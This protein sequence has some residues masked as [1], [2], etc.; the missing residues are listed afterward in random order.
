MALCS[1][2]WAPAVVTVYLTPSH[3]HSPLA[4]PTC[5]V[6]SSLSPSLSLPASHSR[7]APSGATTELAWTGRCTASAL[8]GTE[9]GK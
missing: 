8:S 3:S 5:N 4:T 7:S 6:T 2:P 1:R 9:Q